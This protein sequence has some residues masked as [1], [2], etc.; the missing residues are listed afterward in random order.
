MDI[1]ERIRILFE[2][3]NNAKAVI[4]EIANQLSGLRVAAEVVV[5]VMEGALKAA[6]AGISAKIVIDLAKA[7]A[8]AQAQEGAFRNLAAQAGQSSDEI[9]AAMEKM[10]EGTISHSRAVSIASRAMTSG[11]DLDTQKIS[12]MMALAKDRAS[13]F[14]LDTA[15]AFNI[16]TTAVS[17]QSP[18]M[19]RQIGIMINAS[20]A[21]EIYA[22]KIDRAVNELTEEERQLALL[23][24]VLAKASSG[25]GNLAGESANANNKFESLRASTENL[26]SNIGAGLAPAISTAAGALA[27]LVD[28][29]NAM[30]TRGRQL[31]VILW[32]YGAAGAAYLTALREGA[33]LEEADALRKSTIARAALEMA[34]ALGMLKPKV[35]ALAEAEKD[36][37]ESSRKLLDVYSRAI[38]SGAQIYQQHGRALADLETQQQKSIG[39]LIEQWQS[40]LEKANRSRIEAESEANE[41]IEDARNDLNENLLSAELSYSRRIEEMNYSRTKQYEDMA[42]D[43]EEIERDR[44]SSIEELNHD[45]LDDLEDMSRD[46]QDRIEGLSRDAA[47]KE[48]GAKTYAEVLRIRKDTAARG[49]ELQ[50]SLKQKQKEARES[51]ELRKKEINDSA[52]K[53]RE[54]LAQRKKE[55]EEQYQYQRG[56]MERDYTENVAR[57][58]NETTQRVTEIETQKQ[59]RLAKISE[60]LEAERIAINKRQ[61]EEFEAHVQSRARMQYS[62]SEQMRGLADVRTETQRLADATSIL[63]G[64]A[65]QPWIDKLGEYRSLLS[66]L[67]VAAASLGPARLSPGEGGSSGFGGGYAEGGTVPGPVG[68]PQMAIVHG[69][70]K[71]TPP[72]K[73]APSIVITGNTIYGVMD[74]R[75]TVL[76]AINDWNMING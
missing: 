2:A 63:A 69:G 13:A 39:K 22:Q 28:N 7:S 4:N 44:I 34:D 31:T 21:Y 43:T 15:D 76:D 71:I 16:I 37:S 5:G 20:K 11:L 6:V 56:L 33:T 46:Y 60:E 59:S 17:Y 38:I 72:G 41:Q 61:V 35:D 74:L 10:S 58:R 9:I 70:E 26:T 68:R 40:Y 65:W 19:L 47:D 54:D 75:Q 25:M 3:K 32:G 52:N 48:A 49:K 24:A 1:T 55:I 14:G 45:L 8:V 50:E 51:A 64:T 53:R 67:G 57:M 36:A 18:R 29:T 23:E 30:I 73:D 12:A 66:S 27:D 62:F 42:R